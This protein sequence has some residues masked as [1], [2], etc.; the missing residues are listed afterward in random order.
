MAF[1]DKLPFS[2]A[3]LEAFAQLFLSARLAAD[4][5]Q[6]QVARRAFRYRK[7]H[8]KVSR[9]ER[10]YMPKVD[11]HCLQLVAKVLDVPMSELLRI[12]PKFKDRVA[13]ARAATRHG[14]WTPRAAMTRGGKDFAGNVRIYAGA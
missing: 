8:C 9:I 7:S 6:M 4:L 10:G 5:T 14:F 11:A 2:N 13:V 3:Q 12:D 1:T